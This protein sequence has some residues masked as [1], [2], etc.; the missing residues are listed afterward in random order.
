MAKK[1]KKAD[2]MVVEATYEKDTKRAKRYSVGDYG[3][4][5]S[6]TIY[7]S[8]EKVKTIPKRIIIEIV[9]DD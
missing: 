1:A 8:L 6:G 3:E 4:P 7:F 2:E 5:I 9:E